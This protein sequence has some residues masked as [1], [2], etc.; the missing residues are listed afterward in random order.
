MTP[1]QTDKLAI[2][3]ADLALA[4]NERV[5]KEKQRIDNLANVADERVRTAALA[6]RFQDWATGRLSPWRRRHEKLDAFDERVAELEARRG[7]LARTMNE[8]RVRTPAGEAEHQA[9]LTRW[10]A[11]AANGSR[12]ESP[13]PALEA[14][15]RRLKEDYEALASLIDEMLAEKAAWVEAHRDAL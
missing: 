15:L 13:V 10:H 14:E 9:A 2:E 5:E 12:P 4:T 11:E 1:S 7:E 8:I 6:T 3:T